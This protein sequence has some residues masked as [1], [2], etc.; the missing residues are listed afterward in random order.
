MKA[1]A[2]A[3]SDDDEPQADA[4]PRQARTSETSGY[5]PVPRMK[6]VEVPCVPRDEQQEIET[7]YKLKGQYPSRRLK[8]LPANDQ[9]PF[10]RIGIPLFKAWAAKQVNPWGIKKTDIEPIMPLLWSTATHGDWV[11]LSEFYRETARRIVRNHALVL[12]CSY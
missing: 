7:R 4:H 11:S 3:T 6:A 5:A 8:D 12:S 1:A 2:E 9:V 10:S